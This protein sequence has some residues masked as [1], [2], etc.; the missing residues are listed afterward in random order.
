MRISGVQA[1]IIDIGDS[2]PRGS[3]L[4]GVASAPARRGTSVPSTNVH[5]WIGSF[6]MKWRQDGIYATSQEQVER[7]YNTYCAVWMHVRCN[8]CDGN[9][10]DAYVLERRLCDVGTLALEGCDAT[11]TLAMSIHAL[12]LMESNRRDL[13]RRFSSVSRQSLNCQWVRLENTFF[14]HLVLADPCISM[15]MDSYVR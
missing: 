3:P 15:P 11:L 8:N 13:D 12:H 4:L 2:N 6:M 10:C 14:N 7:A 5:K 1:R 9:T